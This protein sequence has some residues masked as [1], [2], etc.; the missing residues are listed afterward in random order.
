MPL[1]QIGCQIEPRRLRRGVAEKDGQRLGQAELSGKPCRLARRVDVLR[2][3]L[4]SVLCR[5]SSCAE[6]DQTH[7][8]KIGG[9]VV[10]H[11]DPPPEVLWESGAK[12]PSLR[13]AVVIPCNRMNGVWNPAKSLIRCIDANVAKEYKEV[14]GWLPKRLH[15]VNTHPKP[16]YAISQMLEA[17][18]MLPRGGGFDTV[19]VCDDREGERRDPAPERRWDSQRL[20]PL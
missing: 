12:P 19:R 8:T 7:A 17:L 6:K 2:G 16:L 18:P 15:S 3:E 9:V 1:A 14:D 4:S 5:C 11:V 20:F 10:G 13:P